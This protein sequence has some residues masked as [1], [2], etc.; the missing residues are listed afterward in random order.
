MAF[1]PIEVVVV[2][3]IPTAALNE[4]LD[5]ANGAQREFFFLRLPD[6][7][8]AAFQMHAYA[9]AKAPALRISTELF[10]SGP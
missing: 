2:G 1:M 5:L 4:S 10:R 3:D 7:E 8:S 6:H 9:K